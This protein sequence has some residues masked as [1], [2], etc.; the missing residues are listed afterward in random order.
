MLPI[1]RVPYFSCTEEIELSN[2]ASMEQ[3]PSTDQ[4]I[5]IDFQSARRSYLNVNKASNSETS[6][7]S[8]DPKLQQNASF[9]DPLASGFADPS[10]RYGNVSSI[11][12]SR[13]PILSRNA[14]HRRSF[15]FTDDSEDPSTA[16]T[17]M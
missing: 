16:L 11:I 5:T 2:R 14:N 4:Y 7:T 1:L 15:Q 3:D 17:T 6:S 12:Y 10:S 13:S 9:T 8:Y